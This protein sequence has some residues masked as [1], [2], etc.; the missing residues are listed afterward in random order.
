MTGFSTF[1]LSAAMLSKLEE[2][3]FTTPTPVQEKA[4]PLAMEGK[5]VL[6]TAQTGT[7]KT[8]AFGLPLV[9]HLMN[10]PHS[11]A[12]VMTPT[13]ELAVQVMTQIKLF[14]PDNTMKFAVLIGGESILKQLT[15][16]KSR[17]RIIVGTP[18]RIND[19]LERNSLTL[20]KTDFLVLD[21][22]DRMLD[23]GFGPQLE[24]ICKYLPEQ[25]QTLMF[26]ATVPPNIMKL[27][28]NYLKDPAR[29]ET[30]APHLAAPKIKQ[31][32][33]HVKDDGKH[34][35]LVKLLDGRSGQIIVFVKTKHGADRLARKL[36]RENHAA[37]AIHGDLRQG[38]RDRVI[39]SF[40]KNDV[41]ILIATDVAA[42]GLDIPLL[43]T[44]I[45]FDL[46]Q[47]PEDYIHRIGRTGRNGAEG[48]AICLISG[49]DKAKWA[50]IDRLMNPG[51]P[52]EKSEGRSNGGSKK[53]GAKS[54]S[55]FGKRKFGGDKPAGDW[56]ASFKKDGA[57]KPPR[58]EWSPEPSGERTERSERPARSERPFRSER[59]AGATG[60]RSHNFAKKKTY[61]DK[62]AFGG[63]SESHGDRPAKKWSSDRPANKEG[64]FRKDGP[65][66][67]TRSAPRDGVKKFGDRKEGSRDFNRDSNRDGA[68]KFGGTNREGGYKK[69]GGFNQGG[70]RKPRPARSA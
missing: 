25:R 56:K 15:H 9:H 23:M 42:R 53:Y 29:V 21:E 19:H 38:Q 55:G 39:R 48:E 33:I 6:A 67:D 7:G 35:E 31:E 13:R 41:R 52:R 47:N 14:L 68:K 30:A 28:G 40:R 64:G 10:N 45:N 5:D 51:K 17:P 4:I 36:A 61:G 44:V 11:T 54:G 63:A 49:S 66:S 58:R 27:A 18:G 16:L 2:I 60:E 43:E 34:D 50:A 26:S 8:A 59:P 22:A 3:N 20:K 69:S 1:G 70:P 32:L 12:L 65:R 57:A 37:D 46:P 62:P 24:A